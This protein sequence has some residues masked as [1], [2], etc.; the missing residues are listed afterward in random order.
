MFPIIS[1]GA[2]G[3]GYEYSL[4][5]L[6]ETSKKHLAQSPSR[7]GEKPGLLIGAN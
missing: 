3:N 1:S 2:V 5:A 6:L 4:Q 7:A